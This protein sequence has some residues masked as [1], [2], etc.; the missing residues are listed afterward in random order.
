MYWICGKCDKWNLENLW[1][2]YGN[3][4]QKVG[5]QS[6]DDAAY[7]VE[8]E[9]EAVVSRFAVKQPRFQQ[10]WIV[11]E[12]IQIDQ[13]VESCPGCYWVVEQGCN[14]SP[15]LYKELFVENRMEIVGWIGFEMFTWNEWNNESKS[16][17]R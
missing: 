8:E 7:P 11:V 2:Q 6:N 15:Y 14:R 4:H 3:S 10:Q 5:K 12:E 13:K 17:T 9:H 16:K 1:I